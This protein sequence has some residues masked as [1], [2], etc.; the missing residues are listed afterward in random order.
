MKLGLVAAAQKRGLGTQ[1]RQI[2]EWLQPDVTVIVDPGPERRPAMPIHLEWFPGG[3]VI[4][5]TPDGRLPGA[6][7]LL[8]ECDVVYA[9]ETFYD[10]SIPD[11]LDRR[12]VATV[13]HANPE[14]YTGEQVTQL[15]VPTPW[16]ADRL[17]DARVVPMGC[18][19]EQ[20]PTV[21]P[22]D[23]DPLRV[24]HPAGVGAAGDRNGTVVMAGA[25]KR[26][27]QW[28]HRVDLIGPNE[29]VLGVK[30]APVDEW[31]QRDPGAA[32]SVI[33]RR[34]GGLCLPA[35]E[36]LAAGVPVAMPNI[37]P[38]DHTWPIVPLPHRRSPNIRLKG[39]LVP[40]V[41]H[42]L[43]TV[44]NDVARYLADRDRIDEE[45]R[46]AREWAVTHSWERTV[47]LWWEEL[48]A[49]LH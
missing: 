5:W 11:D 36:A 35:L 18:P 37:S 17:P 10:W 4:E 43:Q 15:W 8:A 21:T 46:R 12:G 42:D 28:G 27:R 24:V 16:L 29:E 13:L 1:S 23:V 7:D 26:L 45:R 33:P 14:L 30:L 20:F 47:G 6:A 44:A 49:V 9:A 41:T 22:L 48:A 2:H 32:V 34:Y 40:T 31:W 19:V 39:G 25:A 3:H 38:Q